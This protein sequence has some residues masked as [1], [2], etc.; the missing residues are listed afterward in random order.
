MNGFGCVASVGA[1]ICLSIPK[2]ALN[3]TAAIP[4]AQAVLGRSRRLGR[5]FERCEIHVLRN[6]YKSL[7]YIG[8]RCHGLWSTLSCMS[9]R[10]Q[11]CFDNHCGSVGILGIVGTG[12]LGVPSFIP[13]SSVL[14]FSMTLGSLADK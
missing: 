6:I 5:L 3:T 1:V 10:R 13:L 7:T 8:I 2:P 11:V 9:T 14:L 12:Y 4:G